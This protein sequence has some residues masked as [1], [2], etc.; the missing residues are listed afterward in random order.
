MSIILTNAKVAATMSQLELRARAGD[1][2]AQAEMT[3]K[4]WDFANTLADDAK[5]GADSQVRK[6]QLSK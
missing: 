5:V 6:E 4:C 1:P 2:W 3:R